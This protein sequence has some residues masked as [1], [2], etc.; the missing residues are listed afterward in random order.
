MGALFIG[1]I[2]FTL[3]MRSLPQLSTWHTTLL[4]HEFTSHS[5][6]KNIQAY[7]NLETKLFDELKTEV[8][9]KT[10][11]TEQNRLNR[12][13]NESISNPSLWK[14]NWNK[15]FEM[16]VKNP[17]GAVL[18][19]HGMSDSPYSLHTQAEYL[20]KNGFW[21]L[22]LRMPGHGTI[23]SGLRNMKWQDMAAVV[24]L[25]MKHLDEKVGTK[26]IH[27]MGYSTGAP[28][29]L[30]YTLKALKEKSLLRVPN[31][32]VFYS[33]AIG[34]SAAAPLAVWQSRV[35]Y[36]LGLPKLEWNAIVPEY[37][38][39]K[40]GSFA[41]N[42]GDQVYRLAKKVQKQFDYL[43][44][45]PSKKPF[46]TVLSFS[47]IVDSTVSVPAVID[48][49]FN[50]LPKAGKN[51]HTLLLFDI[52]HHFDRNN[53]VKA[54]VSENLQHLRNTPIKENYT[55]E[56]ISNINTLDTDV[57]RIS[58]R[59][60]VEYLPYQ[61]SKSLYSLSHLA[62]PISPNDPLYGN[63]NAPTSPGIQLGHL[64]IYGET[65][66][67]QISSSSLLRQRWNPF[68]GYTK[69]RVL[70]FLDEMY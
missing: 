25:G 12:Y 60:K 45:H 16:K 43:E 6:V 55:F 65:G 42:A 2:A 15:S 35:G 9:D 14:P 8:Y 4:E 68:H 50:R 5:N 38:P 17:K 64:A 46:P 51:K 33:P 56:L 24:E 11:H 53:I 22:G 34:V 36:I 41:V 3:Y 44:K 32:L 26:P 66:I 67:L 19:L 27:I 20:H 10:L 31:S 52:N 37:D 54:S 23:P 39:F 1:I 59:N 49:L 7:M 40:Y 63:E 47:S 61:W 13:T 28:L 70:T 30:N 62:M 29:A 48:N 69:Q 58:K 18:L 57:Q 21:V